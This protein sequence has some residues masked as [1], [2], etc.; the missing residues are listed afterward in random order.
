MNH[1]HIT[2]GKGEQIKLLNFELKDET[3][4]VRVSVWRN[5]A[6]QLSTL[7]LGDDVTI[8]NAFVKKGYGNRVELSTR[9]GT[10]FTVKP[11]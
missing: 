1:A 6:E 11:I 5:Q 3:G 4:F 7:K 10:Q 8:E 9:G 2:T